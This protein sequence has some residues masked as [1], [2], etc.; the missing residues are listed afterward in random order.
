[1]AIKKCGTCEFWYRN[2]KVKTAV[3]EFSAECLASIPSSLV[4]TRKA[5]M[6][7]TQGQDCPVYKVK[8]E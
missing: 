7:E 4:Y 5:D 8:E 1:M 2:W 6:R 3:G